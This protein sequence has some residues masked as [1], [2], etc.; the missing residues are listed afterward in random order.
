M[1]SEE[2]FYKQRVVGFVSAPAVNN[3]TIRRVVAGAGGGGIPAP[4]TRQLFRKIG[5]RAAQAISKVVVALAARI[6]AGLFVEVRLGA[7][8]VAATPVR[9]VR[10]EEGL[11]GRAADAETAAL[12]GRLAAGSVEPIDDVRSTAA[13]RRFALRNVVRRMVLETADGTG[14]AEGGAQLPR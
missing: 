8:S 4:G 7:G 11:L 10:V 6:D 5:P 12:A 9:L 3:L 14:A 1:P 13:Y 2:L